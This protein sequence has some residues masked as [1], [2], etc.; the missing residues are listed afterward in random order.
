MTKK[1]RNLFPRNEPIQDCCRNVTSTLKS[2]AVDRLEIQRENACLRRVSIVSLLS[3]NPNAKRK[4]Q[5]SLG[6]SLKTEPILD[7]SERAFSPLSIDIEFFE[8]LRT[9]PVENLGKSFPVNPS[10]SWRSTFFLSEP[11][12][13]FVT[14]RRIWHQR[15]EQ[16]FLY[17]IDP[18]P[19]S[20]RRTSSGNPRV[21]PKTS[22]I[23][24]CFFHFTSRN[25]RETSSIEER[26]SHSSTEKNVLF[27]TMADSR[28]SIDGIPWKSL[29]DWSSFEYIWKEKLFVSTRDTSPRHT[30]GKRKETKQRH[31]PS[32]SRYERCI[33]KRAHRSAQHNKQSTSLR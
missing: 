22:L 2:H 19:I 1:H 16:T 21:I 5:F 32:E 25:N 3:I 33:N 20:I 18:F 15:K 4:R 31:D 14:S 23:R 29:S 17:L 24:R 8:K 13:F 9:N 7:A 12:I 27:R 11:S 26:S 10:C 30:K 6:F 28:C